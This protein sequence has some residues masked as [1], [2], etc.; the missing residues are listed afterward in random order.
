MT[1]KG[2]HGVTCTR[3]WHEHEDMGEGEYGVMRARVMEGWP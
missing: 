3:V 2:E 1:N